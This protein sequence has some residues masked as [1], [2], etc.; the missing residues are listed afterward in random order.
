[1]KKAL[2]LELPH[3]ILIAS[4]LGPASKAL[5]KYAEIIK[6]ILKPQMILLYAQHFDVPPYFTEGQI[7]FFAK[8]LK[9]AH[10][11]ARQHIAR[12]AKD[13]LVDIAKIDLREEPPVEAT[14]LGARENQADLI[15]LGS[16][17]R[18]WVGRIWLGSVA[19]NVLR[20]SD[21]PVLIVPPHAEL[22]AVRK[23]LSPVGFGETGKNALNHAAL[24][25]KAAKAKLVILHSRETD[26]PKMPCPWNAKELSV[27]C[28]IDEVTLEGH[29][30]EEILKFAESEN[31][32]LIVMGSDVKKTTLGSVFSSI[33][34]RVLH[35]CRWPILIIP[36]TQGDPR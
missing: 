17:G 9:E 28:E 19:E 10:K 1:M 24:W 22:H 26:A 33:T 35:A 36:K 15:M 32:D 23:I 21:L 6:P 4:D 3:K 14:L 11:T 13:F 34:E 8:E 7:S 29:P 5:M 18:N 31:P 25:A 20:R 27:Q 16:H 2:N 30:A 12:W